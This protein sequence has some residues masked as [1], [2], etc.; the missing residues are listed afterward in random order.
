LVQPEKFGVTKKVA[1]ECMTHTYTT[2][3]SDSFNMDVTPDLNDVSF[4][5][6]TNIFGLL[7]RTAVIPFSRAGLT[8]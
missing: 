2:D 1:R 3:V 5:R 4:C 7:G 8:S 6:T